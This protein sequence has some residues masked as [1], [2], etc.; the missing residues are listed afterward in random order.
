MKF[1]IKQ[2][3]MALS[4]TPRM[5]SSIVRRVSRVGLFQNDK[6]VRPRVVLNQTKNWRIHR[7]A[8]GVILRRPALRVDEESILGARDMKSTERFK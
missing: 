8:K 6:G 4:I 7:N 5:D 3:G 2:P 1:T